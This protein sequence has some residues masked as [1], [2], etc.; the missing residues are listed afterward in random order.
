MMHRNTHWIRPLLRS[1]L[2]LT[3]VTI[4]FATKIS[5][6]ALEN[7]IHWEGSNAK[8][9]IALDRNSIDYFLYKAPPMGAQF[10]LSQHFASHLGYSVEIIPVDSQQQGV[11]AAQNGRAD[12]Y[13]TSSN[14]PKH[15]TP[16]LL[17]LSMFPPK[18]ASDTAS[19][20][21]TATWLF[22]PARS[23]LYAQA[24]EWFESRASERLRKTFIGK[25]NFFAHLR[26]QTSVPK[27]KKHY[28]LSAY[29]SLIKEAAASTRWDWQWIA[30]IIYQES[31]FNPS[32]HSRRNAYGLMQMT[33]V[34]AKHFH[35]SSLKTPK[36]QIA[37]GVNYLLWLDAQFERIGI[38]L[39]HRDD[40]ILAAYNAG[41]AR[42]RQA[43]RD[44]AAHGLSPTIWVG[45]VARVQGKRPFTLRSDTPLTLL[46]GTGETCD[47]VQQI[48][49]RY[50][51][52][53]NLI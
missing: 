21:A 46:H 11:D 52:Y 16:N 28:S 48:N 9:R 53:K 27:N 49:L 33:P 23:H 44:A 3:M 10:D 36:E 32:L 4:A 7:S 29:D 34:T 51:H 37:A 1:L 2:C 14:L 43:Q 31:R 19:P 15:S 35:V 26:N 39:E 20:T 45:N 12:F 24:T 41:Y 17:S 40:F 8:L 42:I 38:A 13:A 47:F 18:H 6:A 22:S 50:S 25:A 5:N 30:S